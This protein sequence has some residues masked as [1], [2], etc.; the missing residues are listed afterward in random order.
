[1]AAK[2]SLLFPLIVLL[3]LASLVC[4]ATASSYHWP[5]YE[6]DVCEC[7]NPFQGTNQH[8]RGDP[9]ALCS[10]L[11]PGFCYVECNHACRDQKQTASRGRCQSTLACAVYRGEILEKVEPQ[12][13]GKSMK[14]HVVESGSEQLGI[15]CQ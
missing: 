15:R 13:K 7:I 6:P 12:K 3:G 5:P 8:Y 4:T 2:Q 11:G 14:Q 9:E 10:D 1:M